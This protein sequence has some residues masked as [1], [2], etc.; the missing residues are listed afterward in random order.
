[1]YVMIS[2]FWFYFLTIYY[3]TY[4]N[5]TH[6]QT[7]QLHLTIEYFLNFETEFLNKLFFSF[8]CV[9]I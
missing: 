5:L 3:Y 4:S 9:W 7:L 8:A 6:A 2:Y 1:M